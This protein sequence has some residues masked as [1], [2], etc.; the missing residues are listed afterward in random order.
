MQHKEL[1]QR[2]GLTQISLDTFGG[3]AAGLVEVWGRIVAR[4]GVLSAMVVAAGSLLVR[5]PVGKISAARSTGSFP[6]A[7]CLVAQKR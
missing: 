1:W 6:L 2:S 3:L 7:Y 4:S 5:S